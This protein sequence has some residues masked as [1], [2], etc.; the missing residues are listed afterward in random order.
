MMESFRVKILIDLLYLPYK[1]GE[2][3]TGV[4]TEKVFKIT[5]KEW[6]MWYRQ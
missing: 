2:F 5:D 6:E 1:L 4:L 3:I